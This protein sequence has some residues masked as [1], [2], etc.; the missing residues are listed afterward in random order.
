M[1][2]VE[3]RC[4]GQIL[5]RERDCTSMAGSTQRGHG[6][7]AVWLVR[8]R[9]PSVLTPTGADQNARVGDRGR[10]CHAGARRY[11][12]FLA[13]GAAFAAGAL[14]VARLLGGQPWG[15]SRSR[16]GAA[17]LAAAAAFAAGA[18]A[19]VVL[20]A[21]ALGAAA[22]AA[23][24]LAA[25]VFAA[26]LRR[27]LGRSGPGGLRS[28]GGRLGGDRGRGGLGA[29]AAGQRGAGLAGGGLGALGL[30]GLAGRDAGLGGLDRGSL[31]GGL[32]DVARA[33]DARAS[34]WRH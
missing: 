16:L 17:A 32:R 11:S 7:L 1:T 14:A 9:V 4:R 31:A 25:V 8:V 20:A 6:S 29:R 5:T 24:A 10:W 18:L 13:F 28:G 15:A 27:G 26:A 19:V 21:A 34:R 12:A 22:L 23:G 33:H 2:L 3:S 30:D